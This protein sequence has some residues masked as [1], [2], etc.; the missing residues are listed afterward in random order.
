MI[1][2]DIERG[3]DDIPAD[4]PDAVAAGIAADLAAGPEAIDD[5]PP[6]RFVVQPSLPVC[7]ANLAAPGATGKTTLLLNEKT[8]V[9][10]GA[11]LYGRG[12]DRDGLCVLVTG[13]DGASH[14]RYLLRRVIE[15]GIACGHLSEQRASIAKAG[16]KIIG[17]SRA[18][19]GALV[20]VLPHEAGFRPSAAFRTLIDQ[21]RPLHP[22]YVSIDPASLFGPGERFGN[23]GD[24]YLA[25]LLHATALDL[26]ACVQMVDHVSQAVARGGIVD[27]YAARGGTAKTDNARLARQLVKFTGGDDTAP[28]AVSPEDIAE[29]RILRLHWTKKN[30]GEPVAPVWL[31]RRGFWIEHVQGASTEQ[32]ATARK[33]VRDR[34]Q[35]D[36]ALAVRAAV[37]SGLA[38]GRRLSA[39][40][41]EDAG[42]L[43]TDGIPLP[44]K[45][46]RAGIV[47]AQQ[48]GHVVRRELPPDEQQG[49]RKHYLDIGLPA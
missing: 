35:F 49:A 2:A 7:G 20:D 43:G 8:A 3:L 30:Y 5:A 38:Q 45:R 17:W 36:D 21:L 34:Q 40:Q 12:V 37:E 10:T 29:G 16:I 27:Q 39:N 15:D 4:I 19:Y 1:A 47:L 41:L 11:D 48:H 9:A 42:V 18:E 13:E 25:A 46:L 22:V 31:R 33:E 24:A 14:G 23:D 28:P 6:P 26:G 44:R 32:V